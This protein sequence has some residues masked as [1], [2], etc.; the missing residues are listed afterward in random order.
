MPVL[1]PI[2]HGGTSMGHDAMRFAD[3]YASESVRACVLRIERFQLGLDR[4]AVPRTRMG[5]V[6]LP[7]FVGGAR[8]GSPQTL[9][10]AATV[11]PIGVDCLRSAVDRDPSRAFSPL[12]NVT[13]AAMSSRDV[14]MTQ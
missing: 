13:I 12:R 9:G 1:E 8:Y 2:E 11:V 10:A 7:R 5:G 3:S 6:T 14:S 4:P